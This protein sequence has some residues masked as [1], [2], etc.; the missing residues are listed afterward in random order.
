MGGHGIILE[1]GIC[2]GLERRWEQKHALATA[3]QRKDMALITQFWET[4]PLDI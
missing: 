2:C 1:V 4:I 3:E